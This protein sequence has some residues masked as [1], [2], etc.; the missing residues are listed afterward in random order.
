VGAVD[1]PGRVERL[2]GDVKAAAK[3]LKSLRKA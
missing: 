2:L 3:E 1:V